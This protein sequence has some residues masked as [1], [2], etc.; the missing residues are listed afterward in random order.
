MLWEPKLVPQGQ[1]R[2]WWG[3]AGTVRAL[4]PALRGRGRLPSRP[5][6]RGTQSDSI[7]RSVCCSFSESG[8]LVGTAGGVSLGPG[9]T[10]SF[11]GCGLGRAG[12]GRGPG[13]GGGQGVEGAWRPGGMRTSREFSELSP[14]TSS[15]GGRAEGC[16]LVGLPALSRCSHRPGL[17]VLRTSRT[18]GPSP[19]SQA[20]AWAEPTRQRR[21]KRTGPCSPSVRREP[22]GIRR[23][24]VPGVGVGTVSTCPGL[25]GA[26]GLCTRRP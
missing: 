8:A 7:G 6:P 26:G 22:R 17:Q 5:A 4:A 18:P 23:P 14:K 13:T 12:K 11:Q 19:G 16:C 15:G 3:W 20:R 25:E 2:G 24:P 10:S 9:G 21:R 1:A